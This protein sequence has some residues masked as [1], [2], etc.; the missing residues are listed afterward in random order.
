VL[1]RRTTP[2]KAREN[3]QEILEY[4]KAHETGNASEEAARYICSK[5]D[6]MHNR[7]K[8]LSSEPACAKMNF[9][10]LSRKAIKSPPCRL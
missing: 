9:N 2:E 4:Y 5:L 6:S 8:P 1:I 7:H 10:P 3:C